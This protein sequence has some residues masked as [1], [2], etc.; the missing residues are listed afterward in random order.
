[1]KKN[2][3]KKIFK[4]V[5]I[6]RLIKKT[7]NKDIIDN[8]LI[9]SG[10]LKKIGNKEVIEDELIQI[11][12][13]W[14]AYGD[15]NDVNKW[16]RVHPRFYEHNGCIVDLGCAG[17]NLA[18]EDKTSDNWS[19]FF[20][21][22]KRVIGVDPQEKPNI[23]AELFK[24]FVSNFS[25][26]AELNL[27]G[28]AASIKKSSNGIYEVLSWKDF[29]KKFQINSISILKINIEGSEW[30][31]ID[32]FDDKDFYEIDQICVSFHYWL[33]EFKKD[34]VLR[35]ITTIKKIISKGYKMTDLE[36]YGWKHFI[37]L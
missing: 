33:P 17:W 4:W 30:D 11:R 26:K 25:G 23:N 37:K 24:G 34:G 19:G 29:K 28:N 13:F 12:P 32:S 22:K 10:L 3:L 14:D 15:N 18:F 6:D 16:S 9:K 1:M 5:D 27:N 7:S 21:G 8:E 36:L 2:F 20:F 31:L 35:T